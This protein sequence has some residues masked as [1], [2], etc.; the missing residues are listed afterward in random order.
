[1]GCNLGSAQ[2]NW[3]CPPFLRCNHITQCMPSSNHISSAGDRIRSDQM[4]IAI[5]ARLLTTRLIS[6]KSRSRKAK[7]SKEES[8]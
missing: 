6:Q 3:I 4:K 8:G 2:N 7:A 1:M 5:C